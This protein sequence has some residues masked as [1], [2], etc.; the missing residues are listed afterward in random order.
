MPKFP[1]YE[2]AVHHFL[3]Q[4]KRISEIER[5]FSPLSYVQ[6]QKFIASF[7]FEKINS[8]TIGIKWRYPKSGEATFLIDR[9]VYY[10]R[11]DTTESEKNQKKNKLI[12]SEDEV[13]NANDR[14][15]FGLVVGVA[16]KA[17]L[18]I[19]K[20]NTPHIFYDGRSIK[21]FYDE[22]HLSDDWAKSI[23][24]SD[25]DVVQM[26]ESC[27]AP[28]MRFIMKRLGNI[29]GKSLLDIGCGLGEASVYFALKGARVLSMDISHFMTDTTVK[30]AK[31]NGVTVRTHQSSI[32]H[33]KLAKPEKFD[34]I[35]VGN[36]FHHVDI[37]K[38]LQHIVR[39]LKSDG[40]LVSWEPVAY[41]PIIN[42]YRRIAT[43]VRSKDER[44]IKI[45]DLEKFHTYFSRVETTWYWLTTLIIFILM[46]VV[47]RRNPNTER[48]WKSVV[49]EGSSWRWIHVPLSK[50]DSALLKLIPPLRY[51]CWNIVIIASKPKK[52]H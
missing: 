48:Y 13:K 6:W 36:L 50:I 39:Y 29:K 14:L 30:L 37:D 15:F 5:L 22:E 47:Q 18:H 20:E 51:L 24:V 41:N 7:K 3:L 45:A 32:E 33:F 40:I 19:H 11:G 2:S 28:E 25:I 38:A 31:A 52:S 21:R 1:P 27:T 4:A 49:K 34:I 35:Y 12:F 23:R 8:K 16:K 42:I 46:A 43:K 10:T 9:A 44:P 26:N 17:G